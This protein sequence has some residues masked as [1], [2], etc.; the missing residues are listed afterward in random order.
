MVAGRRF[1]AV[2]S[3]ILYYRSDWPE[4]GLPTA[5]GG[6]GLP[7]LLPQS[8]AAAGWVCETQVA[9]LT[10]RWLAAPNA[11]ESQFYGCPIWDFH[12]EAG[13]D[14]AG[15]S[16]ADCLDLLQ[17]HL[18]AEIDRLPGALPWDQAY[19]CAKVV[20]GEPLHGALSRRGFLEIEHR[21]LY[22]TAVRDMVARSAPS[23]ERTF[24]FTSLEEIAPARRGSYREQ[25]LDICREAFDRQGFSRHFTDVF[26]LQ[27]RPGLDYILAVMQLNFDRRP[28]KDFLVAVH[29]DTDRI[30][31]FS[32]VG[33]K[34]GLTGASHTQL[35]SAVAKD[36]R[37]SGIYQGLTR[38]LWQT[39]PSDA[40]L[41]NV[42][43]VENGAMQRAYLQSG[44][45]HLADTVLVRRVYPSHS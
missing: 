4:V 9:D 6:G 8:A 30:A 31:G 11:F 35:L 7:P 41:L 27:R 33:E 29:A 28:L 45:V 36:Y 32:V 39:L 21:R 16:S 40:T 13:G 5:F 15:L 2:G 24:R 25:L 37:G 20:A 22:K 17:D 14:S 19:V 43:H 12:V 44:R 34:A 38:L 18:C 3:E 10:V 1:F 26:L 23:A 42:T